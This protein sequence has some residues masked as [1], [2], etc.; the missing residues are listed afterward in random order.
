MMTRSKRLASRANSWISGLPGAFR[1]LNDYVQPYR[2][3][4]P[5]LSVKLL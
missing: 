3:D 2:R 1:P 4:E 5:L